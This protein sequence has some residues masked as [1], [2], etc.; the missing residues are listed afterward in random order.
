MY[1]HFNR[2]SLHLVFLDLKMFTRKKTTLNKYVVNVFTD[3]KTAR[4]ALVSLPAYLQF[5]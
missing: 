4:S 2:D 5:S 3:T 1:I